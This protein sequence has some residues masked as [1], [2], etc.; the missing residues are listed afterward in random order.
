[1]H[2]LY[3][4]WA[5]PTRLHISLSDGLW[6]MMVKVLGIDYMD[7]NSNEQ[8]PIPNNRVEQLSYSGQRTKLMSKTHADTGQLK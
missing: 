4:Y 1:M 3:F 8:F 7:S 2:V 6:D 5:L